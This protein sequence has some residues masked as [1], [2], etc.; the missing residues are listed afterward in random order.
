MELLIHGTALASF[1][2]MKIVAKCTLIIIGVTVYGYILGGVTMY[3]QYNIVQ[4]HQYSWE[5]N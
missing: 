4:F 5:Y 2:T 1:L 3:L